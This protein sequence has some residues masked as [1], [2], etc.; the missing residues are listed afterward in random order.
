ME[1]VPRPTKPGRMSPCLRCA[2]DSSET[3]EPMCG[4]TSP[5][6]PVGLRDFCTQVCARPCTAAQE[7]TDLTK[8]SL[9]S[10]AAM[11]GI[12]PC[13]NRISPKLVGANAVG[14]HAPSLRSHV[15][16]WLGAPAMKMKM[17]FLAVPL[18]AGADAASSRGGLGTSAK[19]EPTIAVPATRKN[20]RRE[21]PPPRT[22]N[23][24][25]RPQASQVSLWGGM[26]GVSRP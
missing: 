13:A 17:Q 3:T 1:L 22:G 4:E 5:R 23:E 26:F 20:R 21:K 25:P 8:T 9:S 11:F 2:C 24:P 18:R 16:E 12:R 6:T 14:V 19:Y 15:S 7:R 10:W